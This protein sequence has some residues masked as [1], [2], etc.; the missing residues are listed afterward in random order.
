MCSEQPAAG[1]FILLE[2]HIP[3]HHSISS[4]LYNKPKYCQEA[5]FGSNASA[6]LTAC[7]FPASYL[8]LRVGGG[9]L[10]RAQHSNYYLQNC[11]VPRCSFTFTIDTRRANFQ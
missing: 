3:I 4:L 11:A 7:Y 9:V 10:A 8:L 2:I 5:V 6:K 1:A